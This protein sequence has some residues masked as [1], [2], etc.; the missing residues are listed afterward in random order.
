MQYQEEV[1]K[2]PK[3]T[4]AFTWAVIIVD[5]WRCLVQISPHRHVWTQFVDW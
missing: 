4:L 3:H 2:K 5:L 1:T